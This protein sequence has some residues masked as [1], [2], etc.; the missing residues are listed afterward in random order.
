MSNLIPIDVANLAVENLNKEI[1]QLKAD[2]NYLTIENNSNHARWIRA[3]E[4]LE[5]YRWQPIETAPKDGTQLLL[6]CG[7]EWGGIIVGHYGEL[8]FY[9]DAT[10]DEEIE[11]CWQSGLEKFRVTHWQPLPKLPGNN[12]NNS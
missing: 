12:D 4:D 3:L 2:I 10:G 9:N 11:I 5:K 7:D 8:I 1:A 6:Y